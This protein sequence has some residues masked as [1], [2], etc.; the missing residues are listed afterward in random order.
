MRGRGN[1]RNIETRQQAE[2]RNVLFTYR[3]PA[4]QS[5]GDNLLQQ[6]PTCR[7]RRQ[8]QA[9]FLLR[10]YEQT[11]G[12]GYHLLEPAGKLL[13]KSIAFPGSWLDGKALLAGNS[14]KLLATLNRV[15]RS[16]EHSAFV[17]KLAK[18]KTH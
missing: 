12:S 14:A 5:K 11:K 3:H 13:W 15:L 7:K 16:P 10:R 2:V 4:R 8:Y 17:K 9:R 18:K 1:C 6:S